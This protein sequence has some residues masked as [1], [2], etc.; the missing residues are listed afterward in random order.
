MNRQPPKTLFLSILLLPFICSC[1]QA[2]GENERAS[3]SPAILGDTPF[4]STTVFPERRATS[5]TISPIAATATPRPTR[6]P[7]PTPRLTAD[8]VP[9]GALARLGRG[10][11]G[12]IAV[13]PNGDLLAIGGSAGI[14]VFEM[15]SL[16]EVWISALPPDIGAVQTIAWSPDGRHLAIGTERGRVILWDADTGLPEKELEGFSY[17]ASDLEWSPD[18]DT[19]AGCS[20]DGSL[21]LWSDSYTKKIIVYS[22]ETYTIPWMSLHWS[23]E[24]GTFAIGN[25]V[26]GIEFHYGSNGELI[27]SFDESPYGSIDD[28]AWSPDGD[29]LAFGLNVAP[30]DWGG[31]TPDP[32]MGYKDVIILES[33]TLAIDRILRGH[34]DHITSLT[35]STDGKRIAA[36]SRDGTVIIWDPDSGR[37]IRTLPVSSPALR[38]VWSSDGA[39]L[40]AGTADAVLFWNAATGAKKPSLEGFSQGI[41]SVSWAQDGNTLVSGS[42]S[43]LLLWNPETGERLRNFAVQTGSVETA[44]CSP[45][46]NVLAAGMSDG[47]ITL[48]N[49]TSGA[50]IRTLFGHADSIIRLAWSPD[51]EKL[52]SAALDDKVILWNVGSGGIL[53]ILQPIPDEVADFIYL[54]DLAWSPDSAILALV[55]GYSYSEEYGA[56]PDPETGGIQLWNTESGD[57]VEGTVPGA[58]M[59]IQRIAW[60]PD[61]TR[62]ASGDQFNGIS[63]WNSTGE[64]LQSLPLSGGI[65]SIAWSPDGSIL[66]AGSYNGKIAIWK[67]DFSDDARILTGHMRTVGSLTFS[68]DGGILSSGSWDG[69]IILW[70][71]NGGQSHP[72]QPMHPA[73]R[74]SRRQQPSQLI[75]VFTIWQTLLWHHPTSVVLPSTASLASGITMISGSS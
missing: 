37:R 66:A 64:L 31:H 22:S 65:Y 51:G 18:G 30:F 20:L 24:G 36:G 58:D 28:M 62:I 19:L 55:A 15:D 1:R 29:R 72:V 68:P 3:S 27:R 41:H 61:G 6:T 71:M 42:R 46:G 56:M 40:T 12:D 32:N 5:P 43:G 2:S 25:L 38:L 16:Q 73:R 10:S 57:R 8:W 44:V 7:T 26:G 21:F 49:T 70:E 54:A 53:R 14:F 52:A 60:S 69:T 4:S 33:S 9:E 11:I 34:T 23:P 48:W 47:G 45:T 35:W 63:L 75:I 39:D 50:R 67:D 59:S 74:G 13:S 17:G